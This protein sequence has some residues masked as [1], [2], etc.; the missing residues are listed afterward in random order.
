MQ[1]MRTILIASLLIF[2]IP[3]LAA[4]RAGDPAYDARAIALG[5]L[6]RCVTCQAQSI[7]DSSSPMA[8]DMRDLVR[9]KLA[10]GWPDDRI[11]TYFRDRYGDYVLLRPSFQ[12]A[13]YA[14]WML[15]V[16]FLSLAIAMVGLLFR[17]RKE[18]E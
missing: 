16:M 6:I 8:A 9:A 4:D 18:P 15:P 17:T 14:L 12:P 11:L 7:N 1:G 3:A 2:S 5:D 13:T 10:A